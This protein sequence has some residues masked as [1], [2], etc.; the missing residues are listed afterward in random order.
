MDSSFRRCWIWKN[1]SCYECTFS[2]YFDGYQT[3]FVCP[4]TLLATQHYHRTSKRLENFGIRVAKLDGKT[5]TKEK[6]TIKK[7]WKMGI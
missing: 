6:T 5:T 2:S 3:I 7:V 4:T 1:R